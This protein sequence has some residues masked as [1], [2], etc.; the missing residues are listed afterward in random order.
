MSWVDPQIFHA[1]H[2]RDV[3]GPCLIALLISAASPKDR[4]MAALLAA[5]RGLGGEVGATP[6]AGGL[7]SGEAPPLKLDDWGLALF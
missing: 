3:F 7:I 1:E 2:H 6:I 4:S 5:F